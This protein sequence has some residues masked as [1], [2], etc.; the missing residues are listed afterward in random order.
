VQKN[1]KWDCGPGD[2][3]HGDFIYIFLT[4]KESMTCSDVTH[5]DDLNNI[6]LYTYGQL[7]GLEFY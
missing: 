4:L 7:E 1:L 6:R 2:A 5:D 3:L